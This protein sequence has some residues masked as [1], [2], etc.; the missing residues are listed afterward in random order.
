MSLETSV[1]WEEPSQ[2]P[3]T[4]TKQEGNNHRSDGSFDRLADVFQLQVRLNILDFFNGTPKSTLTSPLKSVPTHVFVSGTQEE[5]LISAAQFSRQCQSGGRFWPTAKR[6]F[7]LCGSSSSGILSSSS[8]ATGTRPVPPSLCRFCVLLPP[9]VSLKV[10]LSADVC[11]SCVTCN[12]K[13]RLI[14]LLRSFPGT[15]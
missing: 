13:R 14:A 8:A 9:A 12:Y 2:L 5:N 6:R 4:K 10:S 3:P 15:K 1:P 7:L 11:Y